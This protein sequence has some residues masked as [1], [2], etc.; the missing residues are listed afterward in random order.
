M[1][2]TAI[3]SEEGI[4]HRKKGTDAQQAQVGAGLV[5]PAY[6]QGQREKNTCSWK[7]KHKLQEERSWILPKTCPP[8]K[9]TLP[10]AEE[11]EAGKCMQD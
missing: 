4:F 1:G 9:G 3:K 7:D 2:L 8:D 5:Q 10:Q 11:T 6:W